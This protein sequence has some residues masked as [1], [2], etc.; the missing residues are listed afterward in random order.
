[1]Q[2]RKN[3]FEEYEN[4]RNHRL[5]KNFSREYDPHWNCILERN[6]NPDSNS[7]IYEAKT[8]LQ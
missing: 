3:E 1:M 5:Y 4:I 6:S 7:L 8:I 2:L